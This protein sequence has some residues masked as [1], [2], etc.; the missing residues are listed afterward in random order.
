MR[1]FRIILWLAVVAIVI[2]LGLTSFHWQSQITE[3]DSAYGTP[4]QLIDQTGQ[5]ITEADIRAKPTAIF[6]GFTYC[7]EICP[8][9]LYELDGWL[10][11]ADPSGDRINAYFVTVDP[12]RDTSDILNLYISNVT[13]RIT[14]ITGDKD[15][16]FDML[17]GYNVYFKKVPYDD[18]DPSLGY[19]MDHTASIFLLKKGGLFKGT[20]AYGENPETAV[21]KLKNL[22]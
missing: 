21:Q 22:L 9:T 10:D 11:E 2:V 15:K 19:N 1:A 8:T 5:P 7:P 13:D 14:G 3:A 4:F 20:I 18:N 16:V 12:E 17:K 6:F